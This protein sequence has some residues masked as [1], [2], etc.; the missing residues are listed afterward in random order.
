MMKQL[1]TITS[2]VASF[3]GESCQTF[4]NWKLHTH[5]QWRPLDQL[6]LVQ[7]EIRRL[8]GSIMAQGNRDAN[9]TSPS[10]EQSC[11]SLY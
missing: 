2:Y 8:E 4:S 6:E 5:A 10:R 9:C 11:E 7:G 1:S 3:K